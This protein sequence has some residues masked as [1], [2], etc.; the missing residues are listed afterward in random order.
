LADLIAEEGTKVH[1]LGRLRVLLVDDDSSFRAAVDAVL[2]TDGRFEI[3]G[4]AENG[5]DAL[6][7]V[8]ALAPDCV[9]LDLNMPRLGGIETARLLRQRHPEV[10]VVI[11]TSSDHAADV[12]AASA[13]GVH[14]FM[15][16]TQV[17]T[18]A[19]GIFPA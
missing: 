11:V 4:E 14:A 1:A 7:L 10:R 12:E 8:P 18:L 13:I 17:A 2:R 15:A 9:L 16:K 6:A 3:V 19:D 5:Q